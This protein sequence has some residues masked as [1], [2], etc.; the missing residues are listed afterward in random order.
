VTSGPESASALADPGQI[1]H[2]VDIASQ[3]PRGGFR[4]MLASS[5]PAT[6]PV[7]HSDA[8]RSPAGSDC[9]TVRAGPPERGGPYLVVVAAT[10]QRRGCETRHRGRCS[11]GL[12]LT[13]QFGRVHASWATIWSGPPAGG[14]A[15]VR[16]GTE[17]AALQVH[18]IH[19]REPGRQMPLRSTPKI[20][21]AIPEAP[22]SI[23]RC[24]T[25]RPLSDRRPVAEGVRAPL[26]R[27]RPSGGAS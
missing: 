15:F 9:R 16:A 14:Y 13:F 23:A 21:N 8:G 3:R 1:A 2:I 20:S 25:P 5:L 7:A 12:R 26:S 4:N 22:R 17:P 6:P 27:P 10:R 24:G 18:R 19:Q 11:T